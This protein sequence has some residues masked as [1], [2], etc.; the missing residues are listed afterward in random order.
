MYKS[1]YFQ[2]DDEFNEP[3]F[4]KDA[5]R[6]QVFGW[7][8]MILA[9]FWSATIIIPLVLR[10]APPPT[11]AFML[12]NDSSKT[13]NQYRWIS[14]ER[15]SRH[16]PIAVV[17][18]EDQKFPQHWGFD[19]EAIGKA[20]D[21]NK[22]RARPRGAS[23]ISQ[24]VAKNLFLWSGRSYV[25]KGL[26]AYFT[27]IIELLWPKRR[28]LEV[29]LNIA[30][31]GPGIFGVEAAGYA[32]FNKPASQLHKSEAALLAA[33]L[34]NPRKLKAARPSE[35]VRVRATQIEQQMERLGGPAYLKD[36]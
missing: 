1:I 8:L 13:P 21:E 29:Y 14:Y 19:F 27:M 26:E 25:R 3:P 20:M 16:M 4:N 18:A 34:P 31:F 7:I 17:A 35:Y 24:Q 2:Y 6:K 15:I 28:I 10:W 36:M 9:G 11:S 22:W 33:V 5:R 23:T 32:Y 30:Q 12:F